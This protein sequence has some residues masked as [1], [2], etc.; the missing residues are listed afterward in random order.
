MESEQR[1]G[2]RGGRREGENSGCNSGDTNRDKV[3]QKQLIQ[4]KDEGGGDTETHSE[5][6]QEKHVG[7]IISEAEK[8]FNV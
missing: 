3:K 2:D 1:N 4:D 8:T 7:Y 5:P 6:A